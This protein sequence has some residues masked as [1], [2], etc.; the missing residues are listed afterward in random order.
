MI[1]FQ[2]QKHKDKE[3][4]YERELERLRGHLIQVSQAFTHS[5]SANAMHFH[6]VTIFVQN[7][8]TEMIQF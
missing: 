7:N 8:R 6:V 2:S 3:L 1:L 4:K 5:Q